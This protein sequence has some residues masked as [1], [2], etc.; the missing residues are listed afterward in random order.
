MVA[1]A[2]Q[3]ELGSA[4]DPGI[5]PPGLDQLPVRNRARAHLL[6]DQLGAGVPCPPTWSRSTRLGPTPR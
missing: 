1:A 2:A 6:G 5:R 3:D 4:A